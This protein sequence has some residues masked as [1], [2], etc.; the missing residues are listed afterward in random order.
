[1]EIGKLNEIIIQTT[2]RLGNYTDAMIL[3]ILAAIIIM[4][5]Y[6]AYLLYKNSKKK[7]RRKLNPSYAI[8]T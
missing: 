7:K 4:L 8:A 1:M 6:I 5:P 3:T 2:S